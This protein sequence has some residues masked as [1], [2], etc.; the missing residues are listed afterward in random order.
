MVLVGFRTTCNFRHPLGG[1]GMSPR[2]KGVGCTRG[3]QLYG[4][5]MFFAYFK[6]RDERLVVGVP[7][8]ITAN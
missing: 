5:T 1:L 3:L 8:E 2:D 6:R 4:N 7:C